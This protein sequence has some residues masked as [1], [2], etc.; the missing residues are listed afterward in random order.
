VQLSP[1]GNIGIIPAVF[2]NDRPGALPFQSN[3]MNRDRQEIAGGQSN[4]NKLRR[5]SGK[6]QSQR[7][8][9]CCSDGCPGAESTAQGTSLPGFTRAFFI[10]IFS[11]F[12]IFPV[13]LF[14]SY[15]LQ[16]YVGFK[17]SYTGRRF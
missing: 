3:I 8:T 12:P 2:D 4:G 6:Q 16:G 14:V 1:I 9:G 11:Q 17:L 7:C 13:I 5:R 15:P 10:E